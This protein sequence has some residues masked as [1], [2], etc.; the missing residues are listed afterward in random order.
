M[1]NFGAE[2]NGIISKDDEGMYG[3][4]YND[5]IAPIVKAIQELNSTNI[6][7]QKEIELLKKENEAIQKDLEKLKMKK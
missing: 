6:A 4:R 1:N 3:V 2:N 5:L 7:L